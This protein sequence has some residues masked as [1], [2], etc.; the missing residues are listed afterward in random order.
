[1]A[2]QAGT[3]KESVV[4]AHGNFD[5]ATCVATGAAVPI[6]EVRAAACGGATPEE[7][8]ASETAPPAVPACHL[9][10]LIFEFGV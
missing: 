1:M 4:A 7:T 2:V 9:Q 8:Q 3:P 10:Q 6:E 5:S